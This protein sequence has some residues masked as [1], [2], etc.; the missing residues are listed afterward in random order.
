MRRS[1]RII[2]SFVF[3]ASLNIL[4]AGTHAMLPSTSAN[5]MTGMNHT[6][7]SS[8]CAMLCAVATVRKEDVLNPS[9]EED[10]DP[11]APFYIES[12]QSSL[13]AFEKKA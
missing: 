5:A 3:V 1:L 13:A 11:F 2:A 9:S 12:Q 4:A 7:S 6:A 8:N 10:D